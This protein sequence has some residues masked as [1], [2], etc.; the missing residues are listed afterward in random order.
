MNAAEANSGTGPVRESHRFDENRLAD[1]LKEHVPGFSGPLVVEQ[2][3]GGQS[4]PTY[5][6]QT[7]D[8]T[9]VL[10][11]KPPGPLLTG[12]HAVD[13]E[14]RVQ[15]ALAGV[16][17]PVPAIHG[18]CMD[19]TVIGTAF[20]VMDCVPGR[21]FWDVTFPGVPSDDRR[22]YFD[23]MNAT[24]A[25]LHVVD[26]AAIGLGDYGR[27]G[28]YLERQ[29]RRWTTQ[30]L[31]DPEAGRDANV[32]RLIEWLPAHLPV[33][34]ETS[35][36]HGDYRVDNMIFH[37][38]EPAVVAVLDWELSTLG[39]PLVDFA[40]H[41]MMYRMP[42]MVVAGL[43]GA[44][45]AALHIPS[46]RD[47]VAA[48]CRHTG[49]D[50]IPALDYYVAFNLFRLATICHGIKGRLLRGTAS[51]ANAADYAAALPVL[52]DLAWQQALSAED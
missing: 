36:V 7:P 6:L 21:I 16:G 48:Y 8:R 18:L 20:Y 9:Y 28:N 3:R 26:Y 41:V 50:R 47:Y 23:A 13:R 44:D 1:W 34:D 33:G 24:Q 42:P 49:R 43:R 31:A 5:R 35:V 4:N 27:V 17:F 22:A 10:R 30:Y 52:A 32:D 19:D 15:T 25:S 38:T 51:S 37:P 11:R 40:Y 45:L 14:A 2:F 46:E 29:I 12:A 39:H